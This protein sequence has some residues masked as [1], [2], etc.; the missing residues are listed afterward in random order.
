MSRKRTGIKSSLYLLPIM[1][2]A[3]MLATGCPSDP[4]PEPPAKPVI[5]SVVP[6]DGSLTVTW[7]TVS[8]AE[9]YEVYHHTSNTTTG[10]TKFGTE[11]TST[12]TTITGLTNGTSYYVWVKSK[13]SAG[14]SDFSI[15]KS[16]IP[17][18]TIPTALCQYF[19]SRPYSAAHAYYDDGFAIDAS[20]KT[21]YY[22]QDSTFETKWGGPIVKI[23]PEGDASILIVKVA[24]VTGTWTPPPG[25]GK[26][27]AVA[28]KNLT[29]F[30]VNSNTAYKAGGNNTGTDT[31]AEA[32]SE[33]TVTN[34][35]FDY[36]ASTLY[37]PHSTSATTLASL[38]GDWVTEDLSGDPEYYIQIRG[39]KLTEWYDDGDGVYDAT[40][41]SGMLGELGD[42]VDHTD[43]SQASGVLYVKVIN[44]D[45]GFTADKY[46]TVAW[47]G[48]SGSSISFHTNG[49]PGNAGF[50]TLEAAKVALNDAT[51]A[52][53]FDPDDFYA[54][55]K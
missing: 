6:G 27:F 42:I 43:A 20:T 18:P 41:D 1:L 15:G 50:D 47:N 37:Y 25:T 23:V 38:Q 24:E 10:V 7:G 3:T 36:L 11:F 35:Y 26:Y 49:G 4:A 8:G 13:N 46:I 31:I 14:S 17:V 29:E 48:L 33:Y 40:D 53:Q 44:S 5:T 54:Y 30:A 21:F 51:D 9:S 55:I 2:V 12:T 28:Y 52:S 19:Q 45:M 39:T 32:V 34:G 22:Y 16:G